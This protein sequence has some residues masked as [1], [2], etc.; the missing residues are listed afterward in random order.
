MIINGFL[1]LQHILIE[2]SGEFSFLKKLLCIVVVI[3]DFLVFDA[4]HDKL[5]HL[6]LDHSTSY[7]NEFLRIVLEIPKPAAASQ[8][9][10]QRSAGE[11]GFIL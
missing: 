4:G 7:I 6:V 8:D 2:I 5:T 10:D 11:V 1:C 9:F 3:A